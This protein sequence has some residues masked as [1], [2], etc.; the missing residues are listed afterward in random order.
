MASKDKGVEIEGQFGFERVTEGERLGWLLNMQPSDME[1]PDTGNLVSAVDYYF[2]QQDGS[3]FKVTMANHPYFYIFV[4]PAY[5]SEVETHLKIKFQK[6]IYQIIVEWKE[7]LD[8]KNHLSGIR[9]QYMKILFHTINDLV[10]VKSILLPFVTKNNS[11]ENLSKTYGSLWNNLSG[12]L[13]DEPEEDSLSSGTKHQNFNPLNFIQDMREYD[14]P[15]YVRTSIDFNIRVGYWYAVTFNNGGV[16][17]THRADLLS[18]ADPRVFA[19]DIE[20]TKLPLKFPDPTF[21][22]VMM[23]SYMVDGQGY[24]IINRECV[25]EDIE[26]FEYTPKPDYEGPFIVFNEKTELDL[27]HR[28]FEHIREIKPNVYVTYNGDFFDWPFI[29]ARAKF[30]KLSMYKEIGVSKNSSDEYRCRFAS[31]LDAFKW[32]VRD[33]YLPVGSQG[34]KAVTKAKLGY[35]PVEIDPENMVRFAKEKPQVMASYS[36]SDAVATYYLY[37]KYVHPFIFSL[38]TIIPMHPDDVLRKG[39]GTLCETLLMAEAAKANIIFPNKKT[40][41]LNNRYQGHL[42]ES[43]TYVGGH[44]EALE[45]GV[46]RCDL[47]EHFRLNPE[48]LQELLDQLPSTLR[49]VLELESLEPED[50]ENFDEIYREIKQ[51]LEALVENPNRKEFPNIY[52]LDVGAMYPNIILTNRL[53][54]P[55]LV[56]PEDCASCSHNKPDSDCQR[57]MKWTWRGDYIPAT[58]AEYKLVL[59]QL[60]NERFKPNDQPSDSKQNQSKDPGLVPYS[61]LSKAQQAQLLRKRLKDYSKTVYGKTHLVK[62][63]ERIGTVCQRENPFYVDTVRAFRDRRNTY[64][65]DLKL[66][67]SNLDKAIKAR[68][69]EKLQEAKNM[70]ILYDSLQLAHKCILNSFYGYVMRKAARW[71]SM[72][73]AGIVT[74]TGANIIKRAREVIEGVGIP[75]ELDTDGIW[76][77]LPRS[78]PENFQFSINPLRG[79]SKTRVVFSYPCVALNFRVREEFSNHQYQVKVSDSSVDEYKK[80]SECSIL[81]EV[82]GPYRAMI[83]PASTEEGKK[84]KKRYAV[85]HNDKEGSLAELKGFE[86]KR[87]GELKL[88]K[89]FQMQVFKTFLKGSSKEE[90]YQ[91]V[92]KVADHFL[93]ILYTK[94]QN[95]IDDELISLISCSNNMSRKLEEYGAQKSTAITTAKRLSEF[96]G[97][98]I[99][100]DKGLQC[101]FIISK[102]PA[103]APITERAIPVAIFACEEPRR[104]IQLRKWLKDNSPISL[105]VRDILDWDYYITRLAG[106]IRKIVTIPAALQ[107]VSNPVPRVAHPPW[108]LK[109]IEQN[110]GTQLK[111]QFSKVNRNENQRESHSIEDI[112]NLVGSSHPSAAP[113]PLFTKHKKRT[114][115]A[116]AKDPVSEISDD[117]L[118]QQ[119]PCPNEKE[120]FS[121]WLAWQKSRWATLRKKKR[122]FQGSEEPSAKR[123]PFGLSRGFFVDQHTALFNSSWEIIQIAP[124][125]N[126][127]GDFR[128]WALIGDKLYPVSLSVPHQFYLH[129]KTPN[130]NLESLDF[131]KPSQK[132]LPRS[133][134]TLNL[135]KIELLASQYQKHIK[136]IQ[137]LSNH[138][139]IEGVYESRVPLLYRAIL[140]LGSVCKV[141]P[142]SKRTSEG[143][144]FNLED[145]SQVSSKEKPYLSSKNFFK[146]CFLY[147]SST[148]SR[149]VYGIVFSHTKQAHLFFVSAFP[150]CSTPNL[151][152]ILESALPDYQI[153]FKL[154]KQKAVAISQLQQLLQEYK[155]QQHGPTI[156]LLQTGSVENR[157][158]NPLVEQCSVLRDFPVVSLSGNAQDNQYPVFGW[159]GFCAKLFCARYTQ[160]SNWFSEQC[161]FCDY[162]NIPIGNL[163]RDF[164]LQSSDLSYARSLV[165]QNFILWLSPSSFPDVGRMEFGNSRMIQEIE[166]PS[167][168]RAGCYTNVSVKINLRN[169]A[170]NTILLSHHVN[171]IEG[172]HDLSKNSMFDQASKVS[173]ELASLSSFDDSIS[174]Y[175]AFRILK[176][177]V[178]QWVSESAQK[179]SGHKYSEMLLDHIYRWISS[180]VSVLH[181]PNLLHYVH[182]LMKKVFLQLLAEFRSLGATIIYASFHELIV[183][184]PK[185]SSYDAKTYMEFIVETLKKNKLFSWLSI[186]PSEY[187]E[188]LLFLDQANFSAVDS[189]RNLVSNWNLKLY[190]AETLQPLFSSVID[191]YLSRLHGLHYSNDPADDDSSGSDENSQPNKRSGSKSIEVPAKLRKNILGKHLSQRIFTIVHDTQRSVSTLQQTSTDEPSPALNFIKYVCKVLSLDRTISDEVLKL[192]KNLL[193]LAQVQEFSKVSEFVNPCESYV[194]HDVMCNFCSSVKH[195]D[196]L[197]DEEIV[198]GNWNCEHCQ[199]SYNKSSIEKRLIDIFQRTSLA[200][201]LQDLQ[202]EKCS[203]VKEDNA[204][205]YCKSCSGKYVCT[206]SQ[207]S[208]KSSFARFKLIAKTHKFDWLE[209]IVDSHA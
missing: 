98:Q 46:F 83:L 43:E 144:N 62:T 100:R 16:I 12:A 202:C 148:E 102:Y 121:G 149:S 167:H 187:W 93:D 72:E 77:L 162:A 143:M 170:L 168:Y 60:E 159:E 182:S 209:E 18:R 28:F 161:E 206:I 50:T 179:L 87:R 139:D 153:Q 22:V 29:E 188:T 105:N 44:V 66:W 90:C 40:D 114:R 203:L 120:N 116:L 80:L 201:Q 157:S 191:D 63:E 64:K 163:S 128:V 41:S 164:P 58:S 141:N 178:N 34:L 54:P 4:P 31:H 127:P 118:W 36:V 108:L 45:S 165:Q 96:L 97:S 69:A 125:K 74:H 47:K 208:L 51:M 189:Q 92:G 174:S 126:S 110:S 32:V 49:Y 52:H 207:D 23:I 9:K 205:L 133:K 73:M 181:D 21:D 193:K 61:Q 136:D 156:F 186:E 10:H 200:Y 84:I 151:E 134:Q 122:Q 17:L 131:V 138:P 132:Y 95:M 147:C 15:F 198:K 137:A 197:R 119:G 180:P 185:N 177:L 1:Q 176:A 42:L 166:Y 145:L 194:L 65:E 13:D 173:N 11:E 160:S 30:H 88:V 113:V 85:F 70:N 111:L 78:F 184:T 99:V 190:L 24:L 26:D 91:E 199:N 172:I 175:P 57:K 142:S 37:M 56:S 94:G 20:T 48:I 152:K 169:L 2:M 67:K 5:V 192:Q 104:S 106:T 81:F 7:D 155:I 8:L 27:L 79:K 35:D 59:S 68:D 109:R 71:F 3:T 103:G 33:S 124:I 82:D 183:N 171:D 53:Q 39:S 204:S 130:A 196:L 6:H 117:Q 107:K 19:F 150:K 38:C 101:Q 146:S 25:S 55:S 140:Q 123:K 89:L 76:T 86:M 115:G 112:E 75:L 154:V 14:I 195:L 135:Y 129:S 158:E